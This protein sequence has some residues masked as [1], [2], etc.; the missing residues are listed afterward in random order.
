MEL[1]LCTLFYTEPISNWCYSHDKR[2]TM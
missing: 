2:K 1:M